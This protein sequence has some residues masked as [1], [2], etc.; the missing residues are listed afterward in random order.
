MTKNTFAKV[1]DIG[2]YQVLVTKE[3]DTDTNEP[4]VKQRTLIN[5]ITAQVNPGF[6]LEEKRDAFFNNYKLEDAERF[7]EAMKLML[8]R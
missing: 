8:L 2:K 5:E 1:F 3:E 6:E 4:M 7:L